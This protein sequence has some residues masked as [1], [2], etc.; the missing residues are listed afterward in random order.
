[1]NA[2]DGCLPSNLA[3]GSSAEIEEPLAAEA[4]EGPEVMRERV[5]IGGRLRRMWK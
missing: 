1:L 5:D 4:V 3:T 2:V